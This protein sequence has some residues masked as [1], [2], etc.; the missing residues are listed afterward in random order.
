MVPQ[1]LVINF[2]HEPFFVLKMYS[3]KVDKFTKQLFHLI[4]A[5]PIIRQI[6]QP[7]DQVYHI[8]VFFVDFRMIDR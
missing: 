6:I 8:P 3:H 2:G 5:M 7:I 4:E 1:L